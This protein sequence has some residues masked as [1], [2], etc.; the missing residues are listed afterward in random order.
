MS[1]PFDAILKQIVDEFSPDWMIWLAPIFGLPEGRLEPIDP[2]LST[3]QPMAD[4]VFRLPGGA[5]LIHLELQSSWG[6]SLPQRIH[7]YN[8]LLHDRYAEPVRSVA[9]LLRRD[10]VASVLNG[11]Y[12]REHVD[13]RR[14]LQF[15]YDIVR[16]WEQ[17]ADVLLAGGLGTA[18]LG[19]LTDD[20]AD[21]LPEL[22]RRLAERIRDEV[23]DEGK[24]DRLLAS[25][26][27]LMGLRYDENVIGSLFLGV[28]EMEESSTY[29]AILTKGLE[30]GRLEGRVEGRVEGLVE[31][32]VEGLRISLVA[33]LEQKFGGIPKELEAAIQAIDDESRL[34]DA[35]RQLPTIGSLAGLK[36]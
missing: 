34:K 22:V 24:Q 31:G 30:R 20:A 32:R 25:S 18:P 9:I 28:Q 14:Y 12:T 15:D 26:Y 3:V 35:I 10:A 5:G 8:T 4:K 27:I 19:L 33:F 7:L 29:R 11:V 36:L 17:S 2:D 6:G 16:I 1:K 23:A 13:G 21:R